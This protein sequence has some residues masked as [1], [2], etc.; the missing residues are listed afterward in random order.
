MSLTNKQLQPL[1]DILPGDPDL[2]SPGQLTEAARAAL[3]LV[4]QGIQTASLKRRDESHPIMLCILPT[5]TQPTGV[6]WQGAPLLW[7]HPKI[8]P[9][10]TLVHYPTSVA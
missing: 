9:A 5:E 6:L 4:E 3:Q 10:R 2:N 1:Y 8:S 7:I